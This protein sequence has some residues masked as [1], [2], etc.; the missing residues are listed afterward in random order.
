MKIALAQTKSIKREISANIKKHK[1]LIDY[2]I[3]H[4]ADT[5]FFPELS[6][7]GYEPELANDLAINQ[8][9]RIF[10]DFQEI[11]NKNKIT[12]G[13]GMPT[14]DVSGI[15]VS[16]LILQP[17]KERLIYSKQQLHSDEFPYF[18]NVEE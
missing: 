4:K 13:L 1:E 16:M 15:K 11:S 8:D 2:A 6:I 12:I 5:I 3:L 10:N 7:T 17:D 18:V 14:R 9:D